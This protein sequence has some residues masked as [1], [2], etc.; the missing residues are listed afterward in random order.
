MPRATPGPQRVD[1]H[2]LEM[3]PQHPMAK[4]M[5]RADG[6]AVQPHG[7][8]PHMRVMRAFLVQP[9][10]DAFA[11]LP[12]RRAGEGDNQHPVNAF[13]FPQQGKHPLHQHR[14]FPGPRRRAH[15]HAVVPRVDCRFLA[16]RPFHVITSLEKKSETGAGQETD[17][18]VHNMVLPPCR[19]LSYPTSLLIIPHPGYLC[20]Q[21]EKTLS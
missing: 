5:Q 7:L 3:L 13:A 18:V 21:K 12:R 17:Q 2:R 14:R 8:P 16:F 15:Q 1:A 11:H 20:K 4:N 10:A 9:A 19:L 6:R